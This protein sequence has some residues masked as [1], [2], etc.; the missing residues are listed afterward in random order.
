MKWSL[1]IGKSG[2]KIIIEKDIIEREEDARIDHATMK[3]R[4]GKPFRGKK[5]KELDDFRNLMNLNEKSFYDYCH[6]KMEKM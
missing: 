5:R 4:G 1:L 3:F 2:R 6:W